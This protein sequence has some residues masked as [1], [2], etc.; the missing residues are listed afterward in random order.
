MRI[1]QRRRAYA[2][3]HVRLPPLRRRIG[4]QA[5][6]RAHQHHK[7]LIV[8]RVAD[9]VRRLVGL[10]QPL[11]ARESSACITFRTGSLATFF[12]STPAAAVFA[13]VFAAVFASELSAAQPAGA[14]ANC[15]Q[16]TPHAAI[17]SKSFAPI[18]ARMYFSENPELDI[19]D[20]LP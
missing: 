4:Q 9:V 8:H 13:V 10:P 20:G 2:H 7:I 5:A 3:G 19:N 15:A 17:R 11:S 12:A 1:V 6:I 16:T 14:T 18:A